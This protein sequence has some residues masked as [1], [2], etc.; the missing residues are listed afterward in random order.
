MPNM[1]R[2]NTLIAALTA[3]I[4]LMMLITTTTNAQECGEYEVTV[5]ALAF[6]VGITWQRSFLGL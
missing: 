3:M 4:C 1:T 6:N 5:I 2:T